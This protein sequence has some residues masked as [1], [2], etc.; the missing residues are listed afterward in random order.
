MFGEKLL[1]VRLNAVLLE[2][3]VD[4]KFMGGVVEDLRQP[5][6][7]RVAVAAADFPPG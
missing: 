6:L 2:S 7:E 1:Q 4:A 5:D 3:R